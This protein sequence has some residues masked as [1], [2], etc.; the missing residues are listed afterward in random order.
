MGSRV[1]ELAGFRT[2]KLSREKRINI[3]I[4]ST[5][6]RLRRKRGEAGEKGSKLQETAGEA[7]EDALLRR[8]VVAEKLAPTES[9]PRTHQSTDRQT[10]R[11]LLKK[12]EDQGQKR[13]NG[14]IT[15]GS[16]VVLM[17]ESGCPRW[18]RIAVSIVALFPSDLVDVRCAH[19][20][21]YEVHLSDYHMESGLAEDIVHSSARCAYSEKSRS[22]GLASTHCLHRRLG[23][24]APSKLVDACSHFSKGRN[25]RGDM[26]HPAE[27]QVQ[28][29]VQV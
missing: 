27:V 17:K 12:R 11:H 14:H 21:L 13:L 19:R 8:L 4:P 23:T 25:L 10:D 7:V 6:D 26:D 16:Q 18:R 2:R 28:V 29:Q 9:R 1:A 15:P 3:K 20:R 22:Q 5:P 24:E